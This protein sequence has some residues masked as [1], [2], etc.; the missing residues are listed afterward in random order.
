MVEDFIELSLH[1]FHPFIKDTERAK[2]QVKRVLTV[3][4]SHLLTR[5]FVVGERVTLADISLACNLQSL[6]EL[7]SSFCFL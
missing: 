3:L 7:V 2:E 4:N 5:T 6:Y 1:F